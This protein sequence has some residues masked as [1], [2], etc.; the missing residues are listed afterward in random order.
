MP[1]SYTPAKRRAPQNDGRKL[2][3]ILTVTKPS[4]VPVVIGPSLWL[5]VWATVVV[6]AW[7]WSPKGQWLKALPS[8]QLLIT[9]LGVVMGLLLVFRTNTA[10]DRFYEGRKVWATAHS[11]IRSLA[12]LIWVGVKAADPV[13]ESHKRG[14]MNLLIAFAAAT[15]HHMRSEDGYFYDDLGPYLSHIPA[16]VLDRTSS[17][18]QGA[19]SSPINQDHIGSNT[20]ALPIEIIFRLQKYIKECKD[21]SQID[22][23][24]QL[25]LS[26]NANTLADC[27]STF[28]RIRTT[29][30]P[31]AY[32]LHL[33]QT[34]IVYLL[35][36]P[37]QIVTVLQWYTIPATLVA[38]F[39]M[40]GIE[41]I[42]GEIENPFGYDANDLPQ[43]EFCDTIRD[44]V[45]SM[46]G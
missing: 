3:A 37:F 20:A 35:S 32:E 8:S 10:Y 17:D 9:L 11:N 5:T 28:E 31:I 13:Q 19:S 36:L 30:I 7:N 15:K 14:A 1:T 43:D 12:R 21:T 40:F 6:C 29:P 39:T 27:I 24:I 2:S 44:E 4:V 25:V 22:A 33:K 16:F 38:A 23:N 26:N 45:Q 42:G 18:Q 41:A 46:M 34:L